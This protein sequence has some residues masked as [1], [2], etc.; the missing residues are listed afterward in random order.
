M[1]PKRGQ[2][3]RRTQTQCSNKTSNSRL[4]E[5]QLLAAATA[6]AAAAATAAA[7]VRKAAAAEVSGRGRENQKEIFAGARDKSSLLGFRV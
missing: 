4:I 3:R 2:S 5:S 1:N 6:A 7:D